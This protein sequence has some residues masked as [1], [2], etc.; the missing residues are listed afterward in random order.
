MAERGPAGSL[1]LASLLV[2][3]CPVPLPVDDDDSAVTPDD[4]DSAVTPDDDDLTPSTD[5]DDS[6]APS[7]LFDPSQ[8]GAGEVVDV[9]VSLSNFDV[10]MGSLVCCDEPDVRYWETVYNDGD[11]VIFRF[12]FGLYGQ[13]PLSWGLD[14]QFEIVVG[15]FDVLPLAQ[16]IPELQPGAPAAL[17]EIE[18]LRGFDVFSFEVTEPDSLV[19]V[20]A[21][22]LSN[23]FHPW[24]LLLEEDGS[25][26]RALRGGRHPDGTF[27]EPLIAFRS[28]WPARYHV[29][30]QDFF[31]DTGDYDLDLSIAPPKPVVELAEVEPN[32]EPEEWQELGLLDSGR[33]QLAGVSATAGHG[34]DDELNGDLD[35]FR[36]EVEHDTLLHLE[37]W[38]S[39]SDDLDAL[40]YDDSA[41]DTILGTEHAID[42]QMAT[43]SLPQ[44]GD[45]E[46]TGGVPYVLEIGSW[47]GDPEEP[48]TLSIDVV[49]R[50]F[51]GDPTGDDDDSAR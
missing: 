37:L 15:W 35:V 43:G 44:T 49:P 10:S 3:G 7:L 5:D 26:R 22:E 34:P 38:W 40:L 18:E 9:D 12:F 6:A 25:T 41:G 11:T 2:A 48:W 50:H 13:G 31:L 23:F 16:P 17:G 39:S 4:D 45:Y 32:D 33:Y 36:F 28:R 14:N 8:V 30:V 46:L 42:G 29:R 47:E 27:D 20:Q 19:H 1:V 24:L 21:S 51:P